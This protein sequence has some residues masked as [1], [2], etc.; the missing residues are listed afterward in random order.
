MMKQKLLYIPLD[1]RPCN[2]IYPQMMLETNQNCELI[3]PKIS[4]LNQKKQAADVDELWKFVF[5]AAPESQAAILSVEMLIYGGLLPSRLHVLSAETLQARVAKFSELKQQFPKLKLYVSNLIM[6]TPQY[7]SSDEEPD[8]Y[9]TYGAEI[10][11]RSALNDREMR[12]G[13]NQEERDELATLNEVIPQVHVQDYETRRQVNLT[14]NQA[15]I[16][17]VANGVIEFLAIPQ[18]DSAPYGYTARDQRQLVAFIQ[19]LRL[20]RKIQM[21]PGADE[22]GATLLARAYNQLLNQIPKVYI[23]TSSLGGQQ[24]LPLYEDRPMG[25]TALA[26]ILACGA[27]PVNSAEEADFILGY[28][29]PGKVMQ[30]SWDQLTAKDVTYASFRHLVFFVQQLQQW[31]REGKPLAIADCAFANGGE[32]ALVEL[33]DEYE[34]LDHV[35][36]Y[37]GWNTNANT[38]GTT[39]AAAMFALWQPRTQAIT[40]NVM[41]HLLEDVCYQAVVR[42]KITDELLPKLGLNYF[43]LGTQQTEVLTQIDYDL[44]Q[45]LTKLCR[46]SFQNYQLTHL[47][48]FSPWNRMF[49]IGIEFTISNKI[50][51]N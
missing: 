3:T 18:D 42:R 28:N 45:L 17:L 2:A 12:E 51:N 36:S 16:Q 26:H 8:Y 29:T 37:K 41:Y 49:E 39:L 19:E 32:L 44:E 43:D 4:I 23:A 46:N 7:S 5:D 48:S 40:K 13:L 14:V 20:T 15:I 11:R 31:H 24:L 38:L 47:A 35:L 33:L 34:L 6:R 22:V 10:F 30:E 27:I 1:E 21:Y 9:G 25:E 50:E